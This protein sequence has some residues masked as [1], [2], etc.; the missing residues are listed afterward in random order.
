MKKMAHDD[1]RYEPCRSERPLSRKG[2]RSLL[3]TTECVSLSRRSATAE[4]DLLA[5]RPAE[6]DGVPPA[7][8]AREMRDDRQ[9]RTELVSVAR[10]AVEAETLPAG[11]RGPG[12][13][14][15][16]LARGV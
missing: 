15:S 9:D 6:D 2:H 14:L 12:N 3:T 5:L 10:P 7:L 13:G 16:V 8:H 1:R 11:I 4:R